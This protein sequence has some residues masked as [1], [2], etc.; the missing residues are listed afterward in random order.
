MNFALMKEL[1]ISSWKLRDF[2]DMFNEGKFS[3]LREFNL[4]NNNLITLKRYGYL[5]KLKI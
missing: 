5:P 4:S 3:N 1:D 2:N